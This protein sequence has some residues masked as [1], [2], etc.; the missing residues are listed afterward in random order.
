MNAG[1]LVWEVVTADREVDAA[2]V[3]EHLASVSVSI[4]V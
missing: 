3:Q 2:G 4:K 1:L